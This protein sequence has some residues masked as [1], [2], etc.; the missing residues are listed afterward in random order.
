MVSVLGPRVRSAF[1]QAPGERLQQ[2]CEW[3][4]CRVRVLAVAGVPSGNL[5]SP[6]KKHTLFS[7]VTCSVTG[8]PNPSSSRKPMASI[9]W[10]ISA[11]PILGGHSCSLPCQVSGFA[12]KCF[13]SV[14]HLPFWQILS[15]GALCQTV[16]MP[17]EI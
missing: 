13:N 8:I 1:N 10:R 3:R 17:C 16:K 9:S 15:V 12:L 6:F 7:R 5:Y 11:Q 14:P 4:E 2:D